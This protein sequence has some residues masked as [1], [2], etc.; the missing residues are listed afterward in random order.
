MSDWS[1][2][3]VASSWWWIQ[4]SQASTPEGKKHPDPPGG[5]DIQH[6][7]GRHST[8]ISRCVSCGECEIIFDKELTLLMLTVYCPDVLM[9]TDWLV[10]TVNC[11][12]VLMLTV[13]CFDVD[14]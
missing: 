6:S 2:V 5:S 13:N 3:V 10:L 1:T 8:F 4:A 11:T 7:S 14:C 9:L 12:A